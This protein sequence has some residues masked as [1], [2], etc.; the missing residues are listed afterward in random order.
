MTAGAWTRQARQAGAVPHLL[1]LGS[2]RH[3]PDERPNEGTADGAPAFSTDLQGRLGPGELGAGHLQ[4]SGQPGDLGLLRARTPDR[5]TR[6]LPGQQAAVPGPTPL[7]HQRGVQ[8]LPAQERPTL[9]GSHRLLVAGQQVQLLCQVNDRRGRGP[10]ERGPFLR[11]MSPSWSPVEP[12]TTTGILTVLDPDLALPAGVA[13]S[14]WPQLTLADRGLPRAAL[15]V[16]SLEHGSLGL[17]G[18]C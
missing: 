8:A 3:D 13:T 15:W 6:C 1:R 14:R 17:L 4:L 9:T 18:A 2:C 7:T 11:L 12:L 10:S 5:L 16:P